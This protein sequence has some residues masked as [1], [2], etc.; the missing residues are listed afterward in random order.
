MEIG[1]IS[2]VNR[3]CPLFCHTGIS[4]AAE[5]TGLSPVGKRLHRNCPGS[6]AEKERKGGWVKP[7]LKFIFFFFPD[8]N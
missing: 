7:D 3:R 6:A 8:K 5:S 2:W 1:K 4:L